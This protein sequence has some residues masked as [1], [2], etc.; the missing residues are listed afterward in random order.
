MSVIKAWRI[1]AL[2]IKIQKPTPE[3]RDGYTRGSTLIGLKQPSLMG[4][5]LLAT[6]SGVP[7]VTPKRPSLYALTGSHPIRLSFI[8]AN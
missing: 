1:A 4:Q 6:V 3:N 2:C 5:V 7:P 8:K